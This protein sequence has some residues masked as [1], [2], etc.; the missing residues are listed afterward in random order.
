[1]YPTF[2]ADPIGVSQS[3]FRGETPITL[4]ISLCSAR[5]FP[6]R[7]GS[8]R[9]TPRDYCRRWK[10]QFRGVRDCLEDGAEDRHDLFL[11]HHFL[12]QSNNIPLDAGDEIRANPMYGV[13]PNI[14]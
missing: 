2:R 12:K 5:R 4:T 13:V 8:P 11:D 6:S 10:W 7:E 14:G 1:M 3:L 9:K